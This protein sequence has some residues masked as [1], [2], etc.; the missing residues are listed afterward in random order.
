MTKC[1]TILLYFIG[2]VDEELVYDAV[3]VWSFL[4]LL[5]TEGTRKPQYRVDRRVR[6]TETSCQNRQLY[7]NI[8]VLCCW[9]LFHI[10]YG[11]KSSIY[12]FCKYNLNSV[13][14]SWIRSFLFKQLLVH[15][16]T[17]IQLFGGL[18]RL[19]QGNAIIPDVYILI[20]VNENPKWYQK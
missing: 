20:F 16:Y 5:Q 3:P 14:Q 7:T 15:M 18:T 6:G 17:H 9:L 2:E 11:S 13:S 8:L 12:R 19:Y 10:I 1:S 4:R